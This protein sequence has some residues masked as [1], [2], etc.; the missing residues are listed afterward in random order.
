MRSPLFYE[1]LNQVRFIG[2]VLDYLANPT[3][4]NKQEVVNA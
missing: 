4:T 3:F 1:I 2:K